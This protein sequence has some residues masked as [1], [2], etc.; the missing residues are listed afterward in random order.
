MDG[1]MGKYYYR[2]DYDSDYLDPCETLSGGY[3]QV[4]E[5]ILDVTDVWQLQR[6][7]IGTHQS[8]CR[9]KQLVSG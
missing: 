3:R 4:A 2:A 5:I 8:T 7:Y 6:E 1:G 9:K